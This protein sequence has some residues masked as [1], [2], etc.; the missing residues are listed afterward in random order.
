M[1]SGLNLYTTFLLRELL[2]PDFSLKTIS[3]IS[4]SL[5][6]SM[7]TERGMTFREF[8][9]AVLRCVRTYMYSHVHFTKLAKGGPYQSGNK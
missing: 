8:L 3:Q 1:R 4:I 5:Q 9:Y 6:K 7:Y 2:F